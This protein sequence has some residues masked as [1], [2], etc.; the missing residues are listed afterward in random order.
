MIALFRQHRITGWRRNARVFGKPDFVFPQLMSGFVYGCFWHR[1]K[2]E[3]NF[4]FPKFHQNIARDRLVTLV[5]AA[6]S[7]VASVTNL[8]MSAHA[9]ETSS[10]D[11]TGANGSIRTDRLI[12]NFASRLIA[13]SY[14]AK[15]HISDTCLAIA[16]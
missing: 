1:H 9:T 7:R 12:A 5:T 14:K 3:A 8:Q 13:R 4:G 16:T 15:T 2:R 11:A 6:E 10:R